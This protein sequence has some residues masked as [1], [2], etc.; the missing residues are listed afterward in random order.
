MEDG[1]GGCSSPPHA[2]VL[3]IKGRAAALPLLI[4]TARADAGNAANAAG[5]LL[6]MATMLAGV[7]LATD[8]GERERAN[9]RRL[10]RERRG[11]V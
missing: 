7:I 8:E 1:G 10:S 2:A 5:T 11:V 9:A 6:G 3:L 4:S